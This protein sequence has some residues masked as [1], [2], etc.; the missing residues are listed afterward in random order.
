MKRLATSI[1][2]TV[3][4]IVGVLFGLSSIARAS[5]YQ[6]TLPFCNPGGVIDKSAYSQGELNQLTA[7][8]HGTDYSGN[9]SLDSVSS[10]YVYQ[11]MGSNLKNFTGSDGVLQLYNES[12]FMTTQMVKDAA[13]YW[14]IIAGQNIVE[15]VD[16]V[17]KSDEV[18]HDVMDGNPGVLGGQSYD[19]NGIKF[20]PNNWKLQS[21]GI[22]TQAQQN[23][24]EATVIHEIG[25]ALGIP[26]L[27]GGLDGLN[28]S[29]SGVSSSEFMAYWTTEIAGAP[30][31]N[32]K[33]ITST[34]MDA[35]ALA[36]A[37]TTWQ[38]PRKVAEWIFSGSSESVNY[39]TG[40]VSATLPWGVQIGSMGDY[41]QLKKNCSGDLVV[42]DKNYDVYQLD[43]KVL[44]TGQL[45]VAKN[46]GSVEHMG[47]F[48]QIV[49]VGTEYQTKNGDSYYRVNFN[50]EDYVVNAKAF[51]WGVEID[52]PDNLLQSQEKVDE[53]KTIGADA[54][55]Y[56]F[57]QQD[58]NQK[59]SI[60]AA[61][62]G[63]TKALGIV[64]KQAHALIKYVST[65]G[66]IYYRINL[67]GV[68]YIL[69]SS[70]FNSANWGV[71]I[72]SENEVIQSKKN[73]DKQLTIGSKYN[74]YQFDDQ[75]ID[76][77]GTQKAT[78][79]GNTETL[80]LV[81]KNVN[82]STSYTSSKGNTYY[83]F[84]V[85]GTSYVVMANAFDS[86]NWGVEINSV[87]EVLQ[88]Y[89]TYETT[90]PVLRQYN[91]YQFDNSIID[92]KETAKAIQAGNTR[93][94]NL[95]DQQ[96]KVT[97]KY[98]SS[99][100][101][102]YYRIKAK[103][104]EY[105]IQSGA[106]SLDTWGVE[107]G[108]SGNMI[109]AYEPSED[110]QLT[111][112]ATEDVYQFSDDI[113]DQKKTIRAKKVGT[114][115]TLQL[116]DQKV[117]II[118]RYQSSAGHIYYRVNF[119]G[120]EYVVQSTAFNS[121]HWGAELDYADNVLQS[122][123]PLSVTLTIKNT[124]NLYDFD[125]KIIDDKLSKKAELLGTTV[126]KGLIGK[127]VKATELYISNQGYLYYRISSEGT[128]YATKASSFDLSDWGV[129][130][131]SPGEIIQEGQTV[132]KVL[133]IGAS[134]NVYQFN[135]VVLSQQAI[136]NATQAGTA[137][138]MGL[139]DKQVHVIEK[140]TSN[141]GYVYYRILDSGKEYVINS[142]AF[143]SENWGV[144]INSA[145]EVLQNRQS[146][147]QRMVIT[148]TYNAYQFDDTVIDEKR[149]KKATQIDNTE[150][151]GLVGKS[152]HVIEK[153]TSNR[154]N[155]YYRIEIGNE[156]YV[157][158]VGAFG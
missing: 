16:S 115:D 47:L 34:T 17:E 46:M 68:D 69:H 148:K 75:V 144:E 41:I 76:D 85:D 132:E 43:D 67:G 22:S 33:G 50:N 113:I 93:T 96:V 149:H 38:K 3:I 111:V 157:V 49:T 63:T 73:V 83:R 53:V 129:L 64:G 32:M 27:G 55:V 52:T 70:A 20:Y 154:N 77:K 95:I 150:K 152:V 120:L 18:I 9:L 136:A 98:I 117:K 106:F 143:N 42:K 79:L 137:E 92:N 141:K 7:I 114:T 28:A 74:V 84:K 12:S 30:L 24:K 134:Y 31:V 138:K 19:G 2:L 156:Q 139:L 44:E 146:V 8:T 5:N 11:L 102:T 57:E 62:V 36:M 6:N 58:F 72:N 10:H 54:S 91:V 99:K 89:E 51:E 71:E 29:N 45:E 142:R 65:N 153:Y 110:T 121:K 61:K 105:V 26:H 126:E 145:D 35:A 109:Q 140:Y 40:L 147:D 78:L 133:T 131:N 82:I 94:Q 127:S 88:S 125:D 14:N 13:K 112:G 4:S 21:L 108:Q 122:R 87:D 107:I 103:N 39:F 59:P 123:E 151:L 1:F 56:Q 48:D 66:Y 100:G 81:G 130:I 37:A 155:D 60:K 124:S 101:Y 128:S 119:D 116:I 25:H 90:M 86:E 135:E 23:W 80:N 158:G 104:Q 97:E 118:K 15:V